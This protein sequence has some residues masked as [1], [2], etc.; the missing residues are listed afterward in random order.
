MSFRLHRLTYVRRAIGLRTASGA[1]PQSNS[2]R[3]AEAFVTSARAVPVLVTGATGQVGR[4]VVD[5]LVAMGIPVRALT[6]DDAHVGGDY[7]LTGPEPLSQAE[8]V[9]I[10]GA[11]IGRPIRFQELS[12][13]EF[14]RETA[15]TW[16][17]PIVDM[18]LAAWGATM[19][20]PAFVT[21]TVA[22][23]TGVPPRT[24]RQ[25]TVDHVDAFQ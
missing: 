2:L 23:I 8:Q 14:R 5:Q 19:G 22:D 17:R 1:K 6:R 25:W 20:Y 24:F 7:V 12:P 21:S 18:L 10:I 11:S 13:G 4:L 3:N 9:R 16:P 15:E